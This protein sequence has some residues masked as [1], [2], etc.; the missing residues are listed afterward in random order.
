MQCPFYVHKALLPLFALPAEK[1]RVTQQ[2]TGG[3][4]GGKEE[5]PSMLAGHAALLAWKSG[6]PVKIVYDR[7]EDM[8]AATKR[9][10]SRTRHRTAISRDGRLLAMDIE[11]VIDCGAYATLSSVVLSRGTIHAPKTLPL[12][13]LACAQYRGPHKYS[14]PWRLSWIWRT[15]GEVVLGAAVTYTQIR[16]DS[17]RCAEF[18]LLPIAASWTGGI[19]N[20]NRGTLGGNI[21]NASPAANSAP[22]LLV[23]DAELTLLSRRGERRI[24]YRD[25]HTG[26]K[27][28]QILP[29]G[30]LYQIRLPRHSCRDTQY[31]RKVGTRRAQAIA[32]VSLAAAARLHHGTIEDV[33]VAAGSV[34][35]VPLRC[36]QTERLLAGKRVTVTANLLAEYLESLP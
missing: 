21:V 33:R 24:P 35:P 26:Y 11:F 7:E 9:H 22:A 18:P 34:A 28:M 3:A 23:Y 8:A 10:P 13:Q 16:Q 14:A 30:L 2:E 19:A 31:S 15:P 5:Y 25:F 36:S 29:D 1:I 12:R 20:Q 27:Q 4:F 32:K 17:T 6:K